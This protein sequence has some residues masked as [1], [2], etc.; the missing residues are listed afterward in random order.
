VIRT[1]RSAPRAALLLLFGIAIAL[2]FACSGAPPRRP[3]EE[4]PPSPSPK[5]PAVSE[6]P[7]HPPAAPR[8]SVIAAPRFLRVRI[9]GGADGVLLQADTVRAWDSEGRLA[10]EGS[11]NV[12][13]GVAGDRIRFGGTMLAENS[14]DV[15]GVPE[16]RMGGRR[17]GGRI[18]VTARN[19]QLL[20]VAVIPL[21]TYVAAVVSRESPL[22]FHREALAAQA[23]ATRTYAVDASRTPRD[24][25]YDVVGSVEDQVYEGT[26]NVGEVFRAA[27]GE[28]RGMVLLYRGEPA[29]TVFHSTCG[30]RTETAANAWGKDVPYLRSVVCE[31]CSDSPAYRW[32]YR[33]SEAEGRRVARAMGIPAGENLRISIAALTST[34]RAARV[35]IQSGGVS[36]E[37][38]AAEFRRIAGYSRV[39]SL[40]MTIAPAADGW[41]FTGRGYGHGAGMCQFGANRMAKSGKGFREILA[42]YYPGTALAGEAP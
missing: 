14:I 28:T 12:P 40:W 6:R 8:T 35:K 29:R 2:L 31:D 34:G 7:P 16:L 27:A 10:A 15:A 33:M 32:E 20:V 4:P 1:R 26:D 11:G 37:G 5:P 18:R 9:H 13:L 3:A 21:E 30:G 23:V 38:Q 19:G 36:R 42:R 39:R 41:L 25:A 24:T 22:L 17:V